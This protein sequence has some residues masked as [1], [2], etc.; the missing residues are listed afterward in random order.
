MNPRRAARPL[1][2]EA[3]QRLAIHYVGRYATT[4]GKLTSYLRR[5]IGERGWAGDGDPDVA[6]VVA[7]CAEAGYVD[8]AGFAASRSAA[9][10][11]RGYGSRRIGQALAGAGIARDLAASFTHDDETA[12]AAAEAFAR[13]KHIGPFAT[14]PHDDVTRRRAFAAMVRAGHS[15]KL[16]GHFSRA[17]QIDP[18]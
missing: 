6:A 13:R 16:A 7:R 11:R 2:Q 3:L 10:T 9:L 15:P 5:K 1:D 18:E 14:A 12:F 17:E 4:C 8:D